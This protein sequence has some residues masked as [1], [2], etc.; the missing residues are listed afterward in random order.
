MNNPSNAQQPQIRSLSATCGWSIDNDLADKVAILLLGVVVAETNNN[1]ALIT[2]VGK[3]VAQTNPTQGFSDQKFEVSPLDELTRLEL[4]PEET[5][6]NIDRKVRIIKTKAGDTVAK[7]AA[8]EGVSAVELAKYNGLLPNSALAAGREIKIPGRSIVSTK[9]DIKGSIP[10]RPFIPISE[11]IISRPRRPSELSLGE[12]PS[13]SKDGKVQAVMTYFNENY[14][15]P[16]SMRFVRWSPIEKRLFQ[17]EYYWTVQV[18]FRAKNTFN[19][20]VLVEEI[21]YIR[22]NKVIKTQKLN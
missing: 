13:Q 4:T 2:S 3:E 6:V 18:K 9:N 5:E 8:R 12:K 14:N 21:F 22:K 11:D 16:Y 15:D 10:T 20:Y 17:N 19:A 1:N 7:V